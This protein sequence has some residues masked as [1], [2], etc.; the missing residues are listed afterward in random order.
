MG[1]EN[2]EVQEIDLLQVTPVGGQGF[3]WRRC[4]CWF[5]LNALPDIEAVLLEPGPHS[6]WVPDQ[7]R[8]HSCVALSH[9]MARSSSRP[10]TCCQP[11]G[12]DLKFRSVAIMITFSLLLAIHGRN[13]LSMPASLSTSCRP[14]PSTFQTTQGVREANPYLTG[15]SSFIAFAVFGAQGVLLG[16]LIICLATL[17]YQ[18]LGFLSSTT[19]VRFS[20]NFAHQYVGKIRIAVQVFSAAA[21]VLAIRR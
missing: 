10:V 8:T 13:T 4:G 19:E 21:V 11:V 14:S 12:I 16:P 2:R 18:G 6:E 5:I 20:K 9:L 3:K 17:I 1:K 15:I 7:C